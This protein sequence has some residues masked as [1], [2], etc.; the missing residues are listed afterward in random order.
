[1]AITVALLA[2]KEADN[3][4]WLIPK[5]KEQVETLGE[6][7]NFMVIDSM[8]P[9]DDTEEVCDKYGVVYINQEEPY[10]GGAMRTA[11]KYVNNDKLLIVD[12]SFLHNCKLVN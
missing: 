7:Y 1:M 12:L 10:F 8:E 2:Y 6:E 4:R 9:L 5:I 3:L 11:F